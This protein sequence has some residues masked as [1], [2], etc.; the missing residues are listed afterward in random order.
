MADLAEPIVNNSS[1]NDVSKE[2]TEANNNNGKV[3]AAAAG[4][5]RGRAKKGAGD[6]DGDKPDS[7]SNSNSSNDVARKKGKI[8][9]APVRTS[10]RKASLAAS[11]ALKEQAQG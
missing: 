9:A 5:G 6:A 10:Q 1:N 2:E 3:A 4:K 8:D 7:K 11:N